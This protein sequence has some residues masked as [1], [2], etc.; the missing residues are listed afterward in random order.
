MYHT[1]VYTDKLHFHLRGHS[2]LERARSNSQRQ[3]ETSTLEIR[4]QH[5][6]TDEHCLGVG[7]QQHGRLH[8]AL[9]VRSFI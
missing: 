3:R 8:K 1:I 2:K 9:V 5:T 6:S 4:P 7:V